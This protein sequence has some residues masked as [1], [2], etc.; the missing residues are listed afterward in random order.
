[1]VGD[2]GPPHTDTNAKDNITD[3]EMGT[4]LKVNNTKL[5]I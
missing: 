4:E 2:P 3:I 5:F 1:M